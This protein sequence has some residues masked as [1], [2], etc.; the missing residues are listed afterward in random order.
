M[1]LIMFEE[2]KAAR[3]EEAISIAIF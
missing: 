1:S 3:I 2:Y